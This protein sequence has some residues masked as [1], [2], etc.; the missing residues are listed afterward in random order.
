MRLKTKLLLLLSLVIFINC[1]TVKQ[2]N[3]PDYVIGIQPK[4]LKKFF[5]KDSLHIVSP[6]VQIYHRVNHESYPKYNE[7]DDIKKFIV[8]TLKTELNKSIH[9]QLNLMS[10]DYLTINKALEKITYEKYKNPEWIVKAPEEIIISEK[11]YTLLINLAGHYGDMDHGIFYFCVI[12][13]EKQ[14]IEFV[15]RYKLK[16]HILS[17]R[18]I[19]ENIHTAIK[20]LTK[21]KTI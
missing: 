2:N 20:S 11:K 19:K 17:T 16:N 15:D 14:I 3:Y 12:N 10:K 8:E 5:D 6:S 1:S 4:K 9:Y 7:R 18:Q 21:T 13:N